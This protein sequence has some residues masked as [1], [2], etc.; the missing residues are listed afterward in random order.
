[1]RIRTE[2]LAACTPHAAWRAL[3]D[4]RVAAALYAP[5][6]VMEPAA[7]FPERLTTGSRASVRL[8]AFG[9]L[10][11][12]SQEI[13]ITDVHSTDPGAW[14]RT[15]RDHGRP[16]SGPLT[17]LTGWRHEITISPVPDAPHR[18]EWSDE[19]HIDGPWARLFRPPLA[20]MWRWR[21]R[22]LRRL[23]RDWSA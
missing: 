16:L 10:P 3:H 14:P 4:P 21:G 8:R 18:A 9:I 7:P 2:F 22:K 20:L 17:R 13:R 6:L 12:G 11:V 1:M 15:M 19:L 5:L 23:A